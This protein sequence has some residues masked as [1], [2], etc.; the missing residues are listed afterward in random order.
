MTL[1][2]LHAIL[3]APSG[4][5]R[6]N[7]RTAHH[8]GRRSVFYCS[9]S[10]RVSRWLVRSGALTKVGPRLCCTFAIRSVVFYHHITFADKGWRCYG[11]TRAD[12]ALTAAAASFFG[13]V[14]PHVFLAEDASTAVFSTP[15]LVHV[16]GGAALN[17]TLSTAYDR[18]A[19]DREWWGEEADGLSRAPAVALWAPSSPPDEATAGGVGEEVTAEE[20]GL[21]GEWRTTGLT[22]TTL[23]R[24]VPP[25]VTSVYSQL[26]EGLTTVAVVLLDDHAPP[27]PPPVSPLSPPTAP[28]PPPP[29]P[30]RVPMPPP[31]PH[32][33]GACSLRCQS[34]PPPPP[35]PSAAA[36]AV[37]EKRGGVGCTRAK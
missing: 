11:V 33:T 32:V 29:L 16:Q 15:A 25:T 6:D 26:S 7:R 17:V 4:G 19:A 13:E 24:W 36:G 3:H 18:A 20:S 10:E 9:Q 5:L 31:P 22:T 34:A 37:C 35:C 23:R 1:P 27:P 12:S 2:G 21:G 30:P 8:R 28:R 14:S